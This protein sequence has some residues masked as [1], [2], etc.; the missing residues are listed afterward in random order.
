MSA[1]GTD[2]PG[3]PLLPTS[4]KTVKCYDSRPLTLLPLVALI[5]FEVSGGPFGT[6][7]RLLRRA[8]PFA[9]GHH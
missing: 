2:D 1:G 6:E 4:L 8:H 7:V 5:F 9:N 3:E